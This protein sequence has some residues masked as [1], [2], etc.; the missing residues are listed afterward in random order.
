ML[1]RI[2][3]AATL[4]C[5]FAVPAAAQ[6]VDEIL[7]RNLAAKGGLNKLRAIETL[8]MTGTMTVG[9]GMDAPFTMIFKRPNE[10]RMDF[11]V[12]GMT[13][14]QAFDGKR[15]WMVNPMTGSRE[16]QPMPPEA[17]RA[18][19]QQ[20]DFDGP[21]VDYKAKGNTVEL[22]GK[23]KV[24]GRDAWKLKVTLK[25]GDVRFYYLDAASYLEVK[26]EAT[27][28]VRET[29]IDNEGTLAD[30]RP[31]AGVMFPHAMESGPKG[32]PM[33]QKMT[34]Q[35]IEVNIPLDDARFAMP[36]KQTP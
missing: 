20:A 2:L 22:Q 23:D 5:L 26:V 7:A 36:G 3:T 18:I 25:S 6:T 24:D 30:Y 14:T 33:K 10:L 9:P 1:R 16:P 8:R 4:V 32:S 28:T 31:V 29:Q 17:L 15:G 34:V 12:Q 35:K 11:T 19:E 21:L 13:V 27:T